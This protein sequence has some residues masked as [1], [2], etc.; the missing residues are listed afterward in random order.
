MNRFYEY[1]DT[2]VKKLEG[3]AKFTIGDVTTI[4]TTVRCKFIKIYSQKIF[5]Q[6]VNG[7]VQSNVIPPEFKMMIDIRI[8]LDV[9]HQEFEKMFKG[10]CEESGEGIEYSFE[11][12]QPKVPPTKTDN[13]N[14]YW[15][16]F[17]KA[18]DEL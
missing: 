9:D 11:Q 14:I 3:N 2:Q 1:R 16:A 8:A 15:L 6:I 17:R 12:K 5:F 4:N 13:S 7:G 18:I 10:W